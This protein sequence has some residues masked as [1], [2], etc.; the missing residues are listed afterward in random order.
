MDIAHVIYTHMITLITLI[1]LITLIILII[2]ITLLLKAVYWFEL[3]AEQMLPAAINNLGR[4][5]QHGYGVTEDSLK[6]VG[7]YRL[8]AQQG[9]N[10]NNP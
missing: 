8:A 7:Y 1:A 5:Y 9:D 3:A 2:L 10:P 6:A 4:C